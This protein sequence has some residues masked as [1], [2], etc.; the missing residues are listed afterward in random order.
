MVSPSLWSPRP[1]TYNV[2]FP[3]VAG[4]VATPEPGLFPQPFNA[5]STPSR[6]NIVLLISDN[7]RLDTLGILD[8]TACRTPTWDRVAREGVLD[9]ESAHHQPH[10]LS[11]PRVLLHRVPAPPGRDAPSALPGGACGWG[12]RMNIPTWRSPGRRFPTI[13][14][15]RGTSA[16]TPANG[17]WGPATFSAGS[18]GSAPATTGTVPT[19]SGA[20][21][22]ESPTALS[23]TTIGAAPLSV[24][25]TTL[26]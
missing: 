23:F 22:R 19:P 16:S 10:L 9:G 25:P 1:A 3:V 14:A 11:G 2:P 7:Q 4:P 6:P 21:G 12:K 24:P 15:R 26:E 5:M 18:I 13:C 8:R 17:I 20:A